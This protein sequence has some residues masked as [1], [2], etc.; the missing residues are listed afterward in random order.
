[1]I[2]DL[3]AYR[4]V[5]VGGLVWWWTVLAPLRALLKEVDFENKTVIP[6]GTFRGHAG[7][8]NNKFK[9]LARGGKIILKKGFGQ[10][11]D[12]DKSS[13]KRVKDWMDE[14]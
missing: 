2:P 14:L 6:F 13:E 1:V 8:F 10:R 5:Y 11:Q 12:A 3:S 9:K 7:K 4:T